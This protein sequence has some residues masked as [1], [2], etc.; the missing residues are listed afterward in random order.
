MTL[1]HAA[2]KVDCI[3]CDVSQPLIVL[4]ISCIATSGSLQMM[5]SMVFSNV[6]NAVQTMLFNV[7]NS[8]V[9]AKKGETV[10]YNYQ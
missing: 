2:I 6:F 10:N 8:M 1:K 4:I 5:H 7:M 3:Q 9:C